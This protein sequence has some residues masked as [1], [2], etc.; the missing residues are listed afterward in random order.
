MKDGYP[1]LW[2]PF[3]DGPH[4]Q[5]CTDQHSDLQKTLSTVSTGS[6]GSSTVPLRGEETLGTPDLA[7]YTRSGRQSML[8]R[9]PL[10][11]THWHRLTHLRVYARSRGG[12]DF[13]EGLSI[14][15]WSTKLSRQS[16]PPW[17]WPPTLLYRGVLRWKAGCSSVLV[18]T[19]PRHLELLSG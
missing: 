10:S 16:G 9:E 4:R 5:A 17:P 2:F 18:L 1:K 15:A 3:T 8:W 13:T 11:F 14:S 19:K 12:G 7:G 6:H